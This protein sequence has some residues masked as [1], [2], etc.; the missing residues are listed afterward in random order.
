MPLHDLLL[1]LLANGVWGLNF[2]AIKVGVAQFSPFLFT[3]LRFGLLALILLP[4]L[5]WVP[6]QMRRIVS[7]ALV[8]GV[9]HFSLIFFGLSRS[10]DVSSVAIATQL[11]VPF[12]AALAVWL[13]GEHLDGRRVVGIATALAGVL[14]IGFDPIVFNHLD[15]LAFIIGAALSLA[16]ASILMRGLKGVRVFNLQAWIALI[17]TPCLALLSWLFEHDQWQQVTT[18]TLW[19]WSM[20]V[21]SAIGSSLIGHGIV[22]Y[23]LSRYPVSLTTPLTLLTP[24]LA[25]VFGVTLWGD[26]LTAKLIIGG[27]LVI[28]GVG[29]IT[30]R[31]P[32]WLSRRRAGYRQNR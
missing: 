7:V 28:T 8:L 11:H 2:V 5:R 18:A 9:V 31:R 17:A 13:L 30:V 27:L 24:V 23:L 12:S 1:A 26:Q 4:F 21:Y 3:A 6:G 19:Q 32:A 20:P 10:G 16:L 29:V 15:A 14:V 22:Y 25:V